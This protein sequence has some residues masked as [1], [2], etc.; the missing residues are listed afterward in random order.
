[1]MIKNLNRFLV[2]VKQTL[3][4]MKLKIKKGKL[5]IKGLFK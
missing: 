5:G 4:T 2:M 1:M 3:S